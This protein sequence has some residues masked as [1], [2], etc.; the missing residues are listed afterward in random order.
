[1]PWCDECDRMVQHKELDEEGQK[2]NGKK[3]GACDNEFRGVELFHAVELSNTLW[4][5]LCP[6]NPAIHGVDPASPEEVRAHHSQSVNDAG[7]NA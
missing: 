2:R 1:M 3:R 4:R 5:L 7:D 6:A